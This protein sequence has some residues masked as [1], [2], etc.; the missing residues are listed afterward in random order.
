MKSPSRLPV[1]KT[2]KLFIGGEFLR[3][4]SG[5]VLTASRALLGI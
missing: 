5:R 3:S 4:E 1:L 2:S